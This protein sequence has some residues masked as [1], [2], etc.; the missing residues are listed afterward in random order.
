MC[1]IAVPTGT[2]SDGLP[3]SVTLLARSGRDGLTASLA[4]DIHQASGLTLGATIWP[5]LPIASST[6]PT[7]GLINLV[8]VGAHLSGM[9]LNR[10]LREL[11]AHFLSKSRTSASYRLYELAGQQPAKPGLIRVEEDKGGEIEVEI[12]QLTPAAFGQ[13]VAAIPAPLGIGTISLADGTAAKGFLAEATALKG[14]VDITNHGGWRAYVEDKQSA[15]RVER[16]AS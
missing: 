4:R 5:V 14:A 11:D 8:V 15:L 3:A 6:I 10:Q 9:P 12:W 2:R 16:T 13:F 7:D 1:G